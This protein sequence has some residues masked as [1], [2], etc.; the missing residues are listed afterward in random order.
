MTLRIE[1]LSDGHSTTF[2]LMGRLRAEH[3]D[4]L[5]A[6]IAASPLAVTLDL[7]EVTLVDRQVVRFL[8]ERQAEGIAL[9]HC[10]PYIGEWI[11]RESRCDP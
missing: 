7:A 9:V 4:Q 10:S 6:Q 5:N 2:R 11:V 1:T 8:G 3:V